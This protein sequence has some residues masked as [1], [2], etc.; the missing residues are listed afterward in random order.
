MK[1]T[2]FL[3]PYR[4]MLCMDGEY[5]TI[6]SRGI[7]TTATNAVVSHFHITGP[8]YHTFS[9]ETVFTYFLAEIHAKRNGMVPQS[10]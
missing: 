9:S 7:F 4:H 3:K 6:S 1:I 10:F 8:P 5:H 2:E